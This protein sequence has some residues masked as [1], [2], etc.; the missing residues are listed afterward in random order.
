MVPTR[1][2]KMGRHF[3]VKEKLGNFVKIGKVSEFYTKYW[4]NQKNLYWKTEKNT[5]KLGKFV[6]H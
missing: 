4:K 3:P 6:S 2:G 5:G 1:T